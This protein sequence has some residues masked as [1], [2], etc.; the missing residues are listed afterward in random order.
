MLLLNVSRT[1]FNDVYAKQKFYIKAV[2]G[3]NPKIPLATLLHVMT[4]VLESII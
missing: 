3:L 2:G 1:R 4:I